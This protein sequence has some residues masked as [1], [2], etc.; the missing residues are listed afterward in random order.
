MRG[1]HEGYS[2]GFQDCSQFTVGIQA[3]RQRTAHSPQEPER[4]EGEQHQQTRPC[5]YHV[6]VEGQSLSNP[7]LKEGSQG[8]GAA[9][10]GA[11]REMKNVFP[12]TEVGA[13]RQGLSWH[14]AKGC[15]CCG[16]HQPARYSL[17]KERQSSPLSQQ[18]SPGIRQ[19]VERDQDDVHQ[20]PDTATAEGGQLKDSPACVAQIEAVDAEEAQE[21]R[22]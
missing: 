22:Q 5:Y 17:G 11:G 10:G 12:Q 2:L 4:I 18:E 14:K 19:F 15:Q 6:E 13:A 7:A 8:A 21:H 1:R 3:G 9:A 16:Q 20:T